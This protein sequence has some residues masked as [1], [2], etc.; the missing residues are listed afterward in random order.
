[1]SKFVDKATSKLSKLSH[2]QI[3]R[4]INSQSEDLNIRKEVLD[5][6]SDGLLLFDNSGV[7]KFNNKYASYFLPTKVSSDDYLG[8][9]ADDFISNSEIVE[10][11]NDSIKRKANNAEFMYSFNSSIF[12]DMELRILC[13][14]TKNNIL[15]SIHDFTFINKVKDEFRKNESLAAMTTMAAQVAHEIKNPL[16]SMSIYVQLLKK[17]LDSNGSLTKEEAEKSLI[18]ISDEIERL[19]QIA[20]DFLF[21]VKPM[22]VNLELTDCNSLI[23]KTIEV[24]VPETEKGEVSIK[25]NLATTLPKLKLDK[26]LVEQTFLN[27]I[28]NAMQ[29]IK[30][31]QKDGLIEIKSYIDENYVKVDVSDNGCGMSEETIGKIFEPYYTTKTSGTGLGLTTIFKIMKELGGE[32]SVKSELDKGSVFTVSFPIPDSER[33]KLERN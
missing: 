22:K 18:I 10:F 31:G 1:M 28:R 16:A 27:L 11:I 14:I 33:F 20:V 32:I 30:P 29:A 25:L 2:E 15:F 24:V 5:T 8:L 23:K 21:A 7:V 26:S 4:I 12:G 13:N 17:K 9:K 3:S 6:I 19:N